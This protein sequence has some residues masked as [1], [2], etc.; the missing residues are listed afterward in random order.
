MLIDMSL[1]R[2]LITIGCLGTALGEASENSVLPPYTWPDRPKYSLWVDHQPLRGWRIEAVP[3]GKGSVFLNSRGRAAHSRGVKSC[4]NA[5]FKGRDETLYHLYFDY[6]DYRRQGGPQ[7]AALEANPNRPVF[8]G[9]DYHDFGKKS[10]RHTGERG[11][12][13]NF[14]VP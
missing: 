12:A 8:L 4:Q 14:I 13:R 11:F 1:V 6:H 2:V 3:P 9:W 10:R 5:A 7:I